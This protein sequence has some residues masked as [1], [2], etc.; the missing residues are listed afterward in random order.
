MMD[1]L[2]WSHGHGNLQS[3]GYFHP[4]HEGPF[5]E[6]WYNLSCATERNLSDDHWLFV[7]LGFVDV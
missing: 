6:Q 3:M 7:Y 2:Y 4:I 1:V 5:Y